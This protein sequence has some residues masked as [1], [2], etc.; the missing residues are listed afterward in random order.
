MRVLITGAVHWDHP[1]TIR[2]RLSR[3]PEESVVLFG[4]SPGVDAFAKEIARMR[5]ANVESAF[6]CGLLHD[7]G[8][9]VILQALADLQRDITQS[10]IERRFDDRM[11]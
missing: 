7:I 9:P 2:E 8:K 3:L 1:E 10:T 4:D 5:R 11:T 6:L